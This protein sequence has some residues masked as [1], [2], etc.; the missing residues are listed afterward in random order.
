MTP[1]T[2]KHAKENAEERPAENVPPTADIDAEPPAADIE[3]RSLEI[4]E[5]DADCDPYNRTGQFLAE[6]IKRYKE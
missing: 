6:Q 2:W 1:S 3:I 5:S 4:D